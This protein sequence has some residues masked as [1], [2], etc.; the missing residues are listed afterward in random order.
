MGTASTYLVLE[1]RRQRGSEGP[2][3]DGAPAVKL[4]Q[5]EQ[6]N[7]MCV[8]AEAW[9]DPWEGQHWRQEEQQRSHGRGQERGVDVSAVF[10][11]F[12]S[13]VWL[14]GIGG[15]EE[16]LKQLGLLT[17]WLGAWRCSRPSDFRGSFHNLSLLASLPHG[18]EA[19]AVGCHSICL[20]IN[21]YTYIYKYTWNLPVGSW[22]T[23][24]APRRRTGTR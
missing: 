19:D 7:Q 3:D 10:T 16:R 11:E 20:Y 17:A 2:S 23:L 12:S 15:R 22:H 13:F 4:E 1:Y 14:S 6:E 5:E 24:K 9:E 21:I 8:I 18:P